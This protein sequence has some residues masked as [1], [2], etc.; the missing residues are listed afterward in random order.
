MPKI[1]KLIKGE[2]KSSSAEVDYLIAINN[3]ICPIEVK[4]GDAGR[5]KNLHLLLQYAISGKLQKTTRKEIDFPATILC[6][7]PGT[8]DQCSYLVS[9]IIRIFLTRTPINK[10][11]P[12]HRMINGETDTS[13]MMDR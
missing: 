10:S 4:S 11:I 2:A 6:L 1:N 7:W 9:L 13:R 8:Q 5:L 12:R 3:Q